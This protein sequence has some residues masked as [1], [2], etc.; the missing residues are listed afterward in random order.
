MICLSV[1][2][3]CL[4][5]SSTTKQTSEPLDSLSCSPNSIVCSSSVRVRTRISSFVLVFMRLL[6]PDDDFRVSMHEHIFA[7]PLANFARWRG[8]SLQQADTIISVLTTRQ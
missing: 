1:D 5:L 8:P 4:C 2:G 3:A 6:E 7:V